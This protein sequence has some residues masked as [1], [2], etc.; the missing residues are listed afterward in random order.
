MSHPIKTLLLPRL[1]GV[2]RAPAKDGVAEAW[3]ARCPAC[4]SRDERLSVAISNDGSPLIFCHSHMKDH[5]KLFSDLGINWTDLHPRTFN[6]AGQKQ[7]AVPGNDGPSAWAPT[8]SAA[9]AARNALEKAF[10]LLAC[11]K[12][13]QGDQEFEEYLSAVFEAADQI[14]QLKKAMRSAVRRGVAK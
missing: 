13:P 9:E 7:H 10:A 11:A 14:Q 6:P 5:S 4:D 8:Y 2:R 12:K 1:K 3:R